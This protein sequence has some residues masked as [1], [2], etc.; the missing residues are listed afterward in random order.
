MQY[1]GSNDSLF[2]IKKL[3]LY[4]VIM[5]LISYISTYFFVCFSGGFFN[6]ETYFLI[7]D[8]RFLKHSG[9]Y[10]YH[11]LTLMLSCALLINHVSREDLILVT[12]LAFDLLIKLMTLVCYVAMITDLT[13]SS[14]TCGLLCSLPM[15]WSTCRT[16]SL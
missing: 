16:L 15:L 10:H 7:W 13:V 3:P 12:K 9:N 4:N 8:V 2:L 11:I 14:E 5:T 6:V 1:L